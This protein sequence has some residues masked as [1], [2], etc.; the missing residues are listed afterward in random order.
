MSSYLLTGAT[1]FIGRHVMRALA[2]RGGLYH[3]VVREAS[4]DRSAPCST[5]VADRE[6]AHFSGLVA[7][8][9]PA[10]DAA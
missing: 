2:D 5:C 4:R 1:G 8:A 3:V 7:D 9:I 10:R 6:K